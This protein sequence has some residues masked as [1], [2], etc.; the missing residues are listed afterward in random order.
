MNNPLSFTDPSGFFFKKL[1][2]GIKKAIKG[3]VKAVI[4]AH[5]A[6]IKAYLNFQKRVVDGALR[7]LAKVP[8]LNYVVQAV[9]CYIT[10]PACPE[11]LAI[12]NARQ[13]YAV[14]GD[15]RAAFRAGAFSYVGAKYYNIRP[16]NPFT[17]FKAT[18][19]AAISAQDP[20]V[21]RVINVAFNGSVQGFQSA[22]EAVRDGVKDYYVGKGVA[23]LARKAGLT[24]SEF[25]IALRI[26][27]DIG[28]SVAGTSYVEGPGYQ[29]R[30]F[31]TRGKLGTLGVIWD[32]NDT[33][34]GYQGIIDAVGAQYIARSDGGHIT[35]GHSLGALRAVNLVKAG[36]AKSADVYALP[37][38]NSAPDS[39]NVTIGAADLVNGG[40]GGLIFNPSARVETKNLGVIGH[41]FK[42]YQ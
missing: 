38:G 8:A 34:L 28:V 3:F 41:S 40:L 35:V 32:V 25:N 36:Y 22:F 19:L 1:F 27:S 30:G 16:G 39:V 5:K 4:N 11:F 6:I 7:A 21:G 33:I 26:N 18:A 24:T 13:T 10:G 14:T 31:T 23:H 20:N 12:Y 9:G 42:Y 37:F 29:I 2:K 17:N 15:L